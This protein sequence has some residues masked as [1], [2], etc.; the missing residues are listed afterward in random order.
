NTGWVLRI[1]IAEALG[2]L[3]DLS[4]VG[5]LMAILRDENTDWHLRSSIAE[6]LGNLGDVSIVAELITMIGG[7]NSNIWSYIV[8]AIGN[9]ANTK[10]HCMGLLTLRSKRINRDT[11]HSALYKVS[12]RA[13][14]TIDQK[15]NIIEA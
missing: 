3:G 2:N 1:R 10:E 11:L 6:A 9:L 12:R 13:G 7:V 4:I 8:S 14:V 15:G 5:E